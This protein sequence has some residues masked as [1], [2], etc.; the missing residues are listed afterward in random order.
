MARSLRQLLRAAGLPSPLEAEHV[1]IT[2]VT[3]DSRH[4]QPGYLFVAYR[5]V[6]AD[7]HAFIPQAIARGAAAVI[8]EAGRQADAEGASTADPRLL[9]PA[10]NGRRAFALLSAAWHDFPSRSMKVIGVTGTDGKTTTTNLIFSILKAA[11]YSAGMI[12]T[13]NAVIGDRTLDT[14]LHTTTPDAD[15]VQ[16]YLAQM[17]DAGTTHCVLEVTSH[18]L[19]QHRVDGVTFDVA[20]ITNI[21]HD[22]LDLHGSREA[23]RAAKARLFEMAPTHVLN[24]DDDYSFGYLVK[25]PAQRRI[26]YSREIQ[27]NGHYDGWWL[28]PPRV[29]QAAGRV[30]AYAF[31]QGDQPLALPLKTHLIGGYNVSNILAAAGAALAIGAPVEAIQAGVEALRGIPGRMERI[32]EG[33]PYLAVVDFAHTPNSLENVLITLRGMTT[34]RLIVVFGCA[35]ERDTY[36]RFMMGK[37]A[38]E[39]ADVAIFTAEDP[40]RESLDAIFAEMDRGAAAAQPARAEIKHEPDRGEAIRQACALASAG[41]TV[42]ACGKGHEQSMCFGTTEYAWDDREAMRRAIRGERLALGAPAEETNAQPRP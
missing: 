10:P 29:D 4:V 24:A 7:G 37:V 16:A 12:S 13:V 18:G 21:T 6:A 35:G 42:V 34:G 17:R 1:V 26:F 33:Q 3:D 2:G 9:I 19:A 15:E 30:E 28:Y 20:V 25:L 40:R 38:A 39:L 23:Y 22:H 11:G 14:G 32:D 31:R 27:P 8:V 41:D 5:G 36:K